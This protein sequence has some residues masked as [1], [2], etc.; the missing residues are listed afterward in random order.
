MFCLIN[1]QPSKKQGKLFNICLLTKTLG[2]DAI[3]A[4][5]YKVGGL[6]MAEKL[7]NLFHCMWREEAI[8]FKDAYIIHLYNLKGNL[9]D[10]DRTETSVSVLSV[11]G[12][13]LSK[14]Y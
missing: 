1:F 3:P 7:T 2:T 9:K 5:I 8:P 10:C 14:S 6:P 11:A 13:I 12:K 4:E